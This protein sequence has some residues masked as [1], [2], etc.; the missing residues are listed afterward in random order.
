MEAVELKDTKFNLN[1]F[2]IC[3]LGGKIKTRFN[4]G[5]LIN[6]V[7]C[8]YVYSLP[9]RFEIINKTRVLVVNPALNK[10]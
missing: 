7:I 4:N 6:V 3:R 9:S 8:L 1:L 5:Q 10:F 2:K